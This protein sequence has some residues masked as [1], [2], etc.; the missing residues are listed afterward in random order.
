MINGRG[1]FVG[2]A[3]WDYYGRFDIDRARSSTIVFDVLVTGQAD[4]LNIKSAKLHIHNMQ[5]D[6]VGDTMTVASAMSTTTASSFTSLTG[7]GQTELFSEF[8]YPQTGY[9]LTVGTDA[10]LLDEINNRQGNTWDFDVTWTQNNGLGAGGSNKLLPLDTLFTDQ[11]AQCL[12]P[13]NPTDA[14]KG[15]FFLV[16]SRDNGLT[17][18]YAADGKAI[19]PLNALRDWNNSGVDVKM[20]SL[21][22]EDNIVYAVWVESSLV[23]MAAS[24]DA[25]DTWTSA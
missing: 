3:S 7:Y 1:E 12:Y 15:D 19:A 18:E 22:T 9:S 25:G 23:R 13:A 24:Q 8:T 14:T 6:T 11:Y 21:L 10:S 17:W 5:C 2:N 20:P 16:R 4:M